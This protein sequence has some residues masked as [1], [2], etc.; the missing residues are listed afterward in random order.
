MEG[1]ANRMGLAV[2]G[3]ERGKV[4]YKFTVNDNYTCGTFWYKSHQRRVGAGAVAA[5]VEEEKM[6][7]TIDFGLINRIDL[8]WLIKKAL[9]SLALAGGFCPFLGTTHTAIFP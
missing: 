9:E 6:E 4:L 2:M 8:Q 7:N 5:I 1:N 3:P